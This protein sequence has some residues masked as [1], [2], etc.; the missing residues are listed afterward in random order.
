M[1]LSVLEFQICRG[2]FV[3]AGLPL[4]KEKE[5]EVKWFEK[6]HILKP[7]L[8]MP[9]NWGKGI[10]T[11]HIERNFPPLPDLPLFGFCLNPFP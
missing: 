1:S 6:A 7:I 9:F 3:S 11:P 10:P 2:S 5:K 8:A 4:G